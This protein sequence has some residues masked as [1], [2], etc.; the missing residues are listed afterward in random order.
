VH[1]DGRLD[2][3]A[4]ARETGF[5]TAAETDFVSADRDEGGAIVLCVSGTNPQLR[6]PAG[7]W[8][9]VDSCREI[10]DQGGDPLWDWFATAAGPLAETLSRNG[11]RLQRAIVAGRF[12]DLVATG[13][14]VVLEGDHLL[15]PTIPGA[16]VLQDGRPAGIYAG[17]ESLLPLRSDDGGLVLA[18]RSDLISVEGSS[19]TPECVGAP[20]FLAGL[21]ADTVLR[22][23][24]RHSAALL[25]LSLVIADRRTD[26]LL[27]CSALGRAREWSLS[28]DLSGRYR[29]A[30]QAGDWPS[31]SAELLL[32][33]TE[34]GLAVEALGLKPFVFSG[35]PGTDL[36]SLALDA[37]R[38][39]AFVLTRDNLFVMDMDRLIL[40]IARNGERS[41]QP[42]EGGA[43]P[44]ATNLAD[45][46]AP[47]ATN[48]AA[49]PALSP[50][51]DAGTVQGDPNAADI[52]G[53]A[54]GQ[55]PAGHGSL[56]QDAN[57]A[58][59]PPD[60]EPIVPFGM[61]PDIVRQVQTAL[62]DLGYNPGPVDGI[63]G[64]RSQDALDDWRRARG[65]ADGGPLTERDVRLLLQEGS[66]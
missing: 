22:K 39:S 46:P 4:A 37:S 62:I 44:G 41:G 51:P 40:E 28:A 31:D 56:G 16:I 55:D 24:T 2:L 49:P 14:P 26:V 13:A 47:G 52:A 45:P 61:T 35:L 9:D 34:G 50:P 7:T 38:K 57:T 36:L 11:I 25:T 3:A 20:G 42:A 27:D 6:D 15:V 21:P 12:S 10:A 60:P 43:A 53:D 18:S 8:R 19:T 58:E 30:A 33:A 65:F 1:P 32:T 48:P 63:F 17:T 59:A 23:A 66:T 5:A 54:A 29:L 64:S